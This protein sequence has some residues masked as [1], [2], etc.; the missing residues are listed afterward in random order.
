MGKNIV[1]VLAGV[2][3][4]VALIMA[5]QFIGH[6]VY[7]PPVDLDVSDAEA[8]SAYVQSLPMG[9]F[10]F[11]LAS[12]AL[13]ALAGGLVASRIAAAPLLAAGIVIGMV[14]L[15]TVANLVLIA[16]PVWFAVVALGLVIAMFALVRKMV[17]APTV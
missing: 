7:P 8:M 16:H 3:V 14:F 2:L 10:L 4:A 5:I 11:V 1:A 6:T 17:R 15:A 9:A 12:Y 13:G